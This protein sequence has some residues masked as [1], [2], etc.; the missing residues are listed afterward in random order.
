MTME[1]KSRKDMN[2]MDVNLYHCSI[3]EAP[4]DFGQIT[5]TSNYIENN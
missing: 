5:S 4:Y 1:T 2:Q 3:R